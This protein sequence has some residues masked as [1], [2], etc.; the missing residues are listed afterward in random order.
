M[1]MVGSGQYLDITNERSVKGMML[2]EY[3]DIIEN[4]WKVRSGW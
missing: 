3:V 2:R 1:K 4:R